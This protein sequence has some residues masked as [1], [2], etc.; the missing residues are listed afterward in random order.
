MSNRASQLIVCLTLLIPIGIYF[1]VWD[2]YAINVPKWDDHALKAFLL[3]YLQATN[4]SQK[5]EAL[6]RQ[7]NEHRITFTRLVSLIDYSIFGNLNFKRLMLYGN[8]LLLGIIAL[9]WVL[10]GTNRKP[11]FTLL[12]VP[13][14]WLTL[15]HHENMY[16]GMASIQNF[17]VVVLGVWALYCCV[18]YLRWHFVLALVLAG[19]ACLTSGNGLLILPIGALLLVLARSW[20]R[21]LAW[22][23]VGVG[24]IVLY[25]HNFQGSPANPD[26]RV[27]LGQFLRG[28]LYFLGSFAE[29]FPVKDH[30]GV[31]FTLGIVLL[32]VALSIGF[33][34]TFRIIRG[35]YDYKYARITDLFCLGVLLFILGTAVVVVYARAGFSTEGL[36]TSR[37]KIYSFLLLLVAYLYIVI[38]IRG[39]FLSPYVSAIVFLNALYSVFS[40][41]YHLVDAHNF[42][43]Y[44]TTA[45]FNGTYTDRSLLPEKD[46][47]LAGSFVEQTP[48]FYEQWLPLLK[49]ASRQAFAGQT[50][51]LM[52][53]FRAT[54]INQTAESIQIENSS[55]NNQRLQDSGVYFVL[56]SEKRYYLF[57]ALRGRNTNRK[58]L[59]LEQVYFAPGFQLTIPFSEIEKGTYALGM[60]WVQGERVGVM[61]GRDSINSRKVLKK[62]IRT[63]W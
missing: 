23:L 44:Q 62:P 35:R 6:F 36:L 46:S 9:W 27:G 51:G 53:V 57:P 61:M 22:G 50:A 18:S 4:L 5:W 12:P 37:Y 34:T 52:N 16:W 17:G 33:A 13:F 54:T 42:R 58:K 10:L 2:Y 14:I 24:Y 1:W 49:V 29:A 56:S 48:I 63:N 43:K 21:L 25:F 3:E 26:I 7:H 39:S 59:F 20:Q 30:L 38:P 40:T 47:S 28:Y 60:V 32:L 31:C 11:F 45:R 19:M 55:Y 15:S 8:I 41:H